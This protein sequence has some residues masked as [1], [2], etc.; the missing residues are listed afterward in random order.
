[1]S[2]K[3]TPA[4]RQKPRKT[5]PKPE[6][7]P[8]YAHDDIDYL[9]AQEAI[10]YGNAEILAL[11]L[12]QADEIDPRVRRQLAEMLDPTSNH[13]WRLDVRYR[14]R[15]K[16]TKLAKRWKLETIVDLTKQLSGVDPL[17]PR[18]SRELSDMLDP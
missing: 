13:T 16:P 17:D 6:C 14:F 11:H 4:Q 18:C 2:K 9:W 3:R 8:V 7:W 5:A 10:R 15:G 1:M 12:W